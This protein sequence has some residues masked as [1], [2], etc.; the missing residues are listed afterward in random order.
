MYSVIDVI[1]ITYDFII[2]MKVSGEKMN[3][4]SVNSKNSIYQ[5]FE[6]LKSNRNK[7]HRYNEFFVEGVRNIN[8]AIK[9]NW[10]IKSFIYRK[11][12]LSD[13]AKNIIQGVQT[14]N[15]YLLAPELM[16]EL[17]G[18][19]DTSEL[20]AIIEMR[21][22][23]L[24][25]VSLAQQ[26]FIV[27]FDRP[28]NKGN[29]GTLIRSCDAFGVDLLITTGHSIDIYD[30]DVVVSSMGSFFNIPT[31]HISD[32]RA[33]FKYFEW[34]KKEYPNIQFIGTTS[35]K[36]VPI[37]N[38][39]LKTP[40]VLMIENETYGLNKTYKEYCDTLCSIPMSEKSY[41]TSFNVSC[42]AS[43]VMYEITKQNT[44]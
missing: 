9:N 42:A 37:Y 40:I 17:S 23:S 13:W 22:E 25:K 38:Q 35:H 18:K 27:L 30:P 29:L 32:N 11:D 21:E 5:K 20:M 19:E 44:N 14:Q 7:R 24:Q 4:I 28:S 10:K 3:A 6:V 1:A 8:E 34:L 43:I 31:L 15:N 36:K 16:K 12:C 2:S 39:N 41:A 33:L 26:P